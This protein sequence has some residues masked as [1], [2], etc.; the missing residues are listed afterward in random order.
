MGFYVFSFPSGNFCVLNAETVKMFKLVSQGDTLLSSST[1]NSGGVSKTLLKHQGSLQWLWE[2]VAQHTP[3]Y[4]CHWWNPWRLLK[5]YLL[6]PKS[7]SRKPDPSNSSGD[8]EVTMTQ[9]KN[10]TLTELGVS[11]SRYHAR[12]SAP[13]PVWPSPCPAGLFPHAQLHLSLLEKQKESWKRDT[14]Q[15]CLYVHISPQL[16]AADSFHVAPVWCTDVHLGNKSYL[17]H[18]RS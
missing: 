12:M 2:A 13:L 17:D 3:A 11:I 18:F 9:G 7:F 15:F 10:S 8:Q 16:A 4:C 14:A 5:I 1:L 6:F